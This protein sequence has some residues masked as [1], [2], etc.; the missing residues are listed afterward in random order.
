MIKINGEKKLFDRPIKNP[1]ETENRF[2]KCFP[3]IVL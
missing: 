1:Y 2:Q 3:K